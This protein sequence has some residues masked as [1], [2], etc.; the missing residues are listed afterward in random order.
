[1]RI[2][3][4]KT[5]FV[6]LFVD[7]TTWNVALADPNQDRL[8]LSDQVVQTAL[9]KKLDPNETSITVEEFMAETGSLTNRKR[10]F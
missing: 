7:E 10:S 2:R 4:S 6:T 8:Q 5:W 3:S 9:F 1:M